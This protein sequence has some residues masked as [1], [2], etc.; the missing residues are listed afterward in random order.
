MK[1]VFITRVVT[2]FFLVFTILYFTVPSFA[3]TDIQLSQGLK[4]A[5]KNEPTS[6]LGGAAE[7]AGYDLN[8]DFALD[9]VS[10]VIYLM[11]SFLGVIFLAL[12]IY[13]G[14]IWMIARGNEQEIKKA[15]DTITAALIGL[16]IVVAAYAISW[17]IISRLG[18]ATLKE[19]TGQ[20]IKSDK[21][22]Y[23]SAGVN[24]FIS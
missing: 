7:G 9:I 10:R 16:I 5:F 4:D 15:K 22:V 23:N 1:K 12:T 2:I 13:A 3:A 14:Y 8:K 18:E 17:L 11:L 6:P 20:G 21:L 19:T 24:K